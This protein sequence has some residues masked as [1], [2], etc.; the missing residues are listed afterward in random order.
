MHSQI[1]FILGWDMIRVLLLGSN[2]VS[3]FVVMDKSL[4]VPEL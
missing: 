1:G 3:S 4:M 2:N